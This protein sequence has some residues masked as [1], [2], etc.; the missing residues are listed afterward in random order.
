MDIMNSSWVFLALTSTIIS[1]LI[2]LLDSH[3]MM[4]RMPGW[5]AYVLICDV[6]TLPVS[7]VMLLI[8]PLPADLGL[9]PI[10]AILG[11]TLASSVAVV[12]I[13]QAMKNEH[14]ARIAP[15]TSTSPVFVA[16]LAFL[17]LGEDLSW[18]QGFAIA[19]V[20]IGAIMISFKWDSK[21]AA[22][23]HA[24]PV[25]ILLT[26][27]VFVAISNVANKYALDYMTYWNSATLIFL[28]SAILFLCVCIRRSVLREIAG[29]RQRNLT[30]ALAH[31][32]SG[33]GHRSGHPGFLRHATGTGSH[34]F[35]RFQQQ[36]AL[37]LR[38]RPVWPGI[39]SR[40]SWP[41]ERSSRKT[42]IIR[43]GATVLVVSGL[44]AMLI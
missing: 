37:Y 2:N 12:L 43:A 33:G 35:R 38:V 18:R 16:L 17:F 41:P 21:G 23:F 27:A 42:V 3:L 9:R 32:K 26:A 28:V 22:H 34:D 8:F 40:A 44:L 10:L 14:V 1:A 29:L 6:F 30:I 25:L 4:Q 31:G 39:F 19:A 24:R 7:L 15:I 11:S 20:V 5:R 36:A 13:L